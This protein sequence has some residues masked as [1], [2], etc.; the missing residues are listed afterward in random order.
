MKHIE[1]YEELNW[2]KVKKLLR[3]S[4]AD[5]DLETSGRVAAR[6]TPPEPTYNDPQDLF[7]SVDDIE[8]Y[9]KVNIPSPLRARPNFNG[10][11]RHDAK[12]KCLYVKDDTKWSN[13]PVF[14]EYGIERLCVIV[15]VY[16]E[17][18]DIK[19]TNEDVIFYT[20]DREKSNSLYR[21]VHKISDSEGKEIH[22]NMYHWVFDMRFT[23]GDN[24][25]K[26][27]NS[28][29]ILQKEEMDKDINNFAIELKSALLRIKDAREKVIDIYNTRLELNEIIRNNED[30]IDDV[31]FTLESS[32]SSID[33]LLSTQTIKEKES[34][35]HRWVD[36]Y[37]NPNESFVIDDKWG[38]DEYLTFV[39]PEFVKYKS[40]ITFKDINFKI[41][42]S[43]FRMSKKLGNVLRLISTIER[44]INNIDERLGVHVHVVDSNELAIII[45]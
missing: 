3:L 14:R 8:G 42:K 28:Y 27:K 26:P 18:N 31:I 41:E 45:Y 23:S 17:G 2:K 24:Y 19:R 13:D 30:V 32:S 43:K 4:K 39:V 37:E 44:R 21:S 9:T 12:D 20:S 22:N 25:F 36:L 11:H 6:V 16:R 40:I 10:F 35:D 5:K 1:V 34:G 29:V 33:N 15:D 38:N 7:D